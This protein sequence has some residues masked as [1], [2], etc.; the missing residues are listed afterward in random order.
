[1]NEYAVPVKTKINRLLYSFEIVIRAR[2]ATEAKRIVAHLYEGK[3]E[4]IG[5]PK[6]ITYS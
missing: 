5:T 3:I 4:S 6:E 2:N 1:M